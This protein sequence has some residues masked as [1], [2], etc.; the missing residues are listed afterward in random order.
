MRDGWRKFQDLEIGM[1]ASMSKKVTR[2][3]IQQ[4]A[5]IS[6]DYNPVH[7]DEDYARQTV[8]G[9]VIAHGMISGAMI[10]AVLANKLPGPGNIYMS[11]DLKFL[12]PVYPDDVITTTVEII[13][14]EETRGRVKLATW[15][16]NQNGKRVT[17]GT[18]LVS[19]KV[20]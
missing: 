5:A 12:A 18:G 1:K 17:E 11:Q 7:I 13:E 16:E 19:H 4:F 3:M 15:C 20:K 6:D 14:L 9:S 8:F 10:S 2:E